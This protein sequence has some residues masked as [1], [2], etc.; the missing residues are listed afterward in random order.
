[1]RIST[2]TVNKLAKRNKEKKET[3]ERLPLGLQMISISDFE[4]YRLGRDWIILQMTLE[5]EEDE[6]E[7]AAV[8]LKTNLSHK[9]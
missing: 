9:H 8:A 6:E 1:M 7:K 2:K 5:G 3:K 4:C